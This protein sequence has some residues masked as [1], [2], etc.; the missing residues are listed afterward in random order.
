MGNE[1]EI[2][3]IDDNV[4][5]YEL[6]QRVLEKASLV[7]NSNVCFQLIHTKNG[8]E[9]LRRLAH[10]KPDCV[11]LDYSLPGNDGLIVL[12]EIKKHHP[13]LPVIMLTGQGNENLAVSLLKAGAQDYVVK[14]NIQNNKLH[15]LIEDAIKNCSQEELQSEDTQSPLILIVDDNP[16]DREY[17][18]RI[19][20]KLAFTHYHF[21]EASSGADAIK[22][23]E[24]QTPDCILLDYS[25]PGDN[26]LA[27]LKNISGDYPFLPVIILTG[28]GNEIVAAEA[29]K[30]GAQ[31]YL[32]KSGLTS[33]ALDHAIKTALEQKNLERKVSEKD[34]A[35]NIYQ[36]EM[37]DRRKRLELIVQAAN[38]VLWDLDINK[39]KIILSE[40]V[41]SMLGYGW[42]NQTI[43]LEKVA[44]LIH[45]EDKYGS[46][47]QWELHINGEVSVYEN[48]QRMQCQNGSWKWI[49]ATGKIVAR[50]QRGK[51]IQ[52]AG[53]YQDITEDKTAAEQLMHANQELERFAYMASHDLQEPL[54]MVINFTRLLEKY[55]GDQLDDRA[56]EYINFAS[57]S[58]TRMQNLVQDLL[59]YARIG[60]EAESYEEI[61]LNTL[62]DPILENLSSSIKTSGAKIVWGDLPSVKANPARMSSLFQNLIGNAIKYRKPEE[63]PEIHISVETGE[64]NWVFS[65]KD[66]GIG[67]K[68]Q[69]CMKIFEPFKRLHAKGKYAGTGMG[70]AICRKIVEG[71]GGQIW[72]TSVLGEGST[73]C[74]IVPMD[75]N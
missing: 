68:Q 21:I 9:G 27:V 61:D 59:E 33:G 51:P 23:L 34:R 47:R 37:I 64:N 3:I 16:D 67:M 57:T 75:V 18:I 13:Y 62:R 31:H 53:I 11:L 42:N 56:K 52:I 22:Q 26:G 20:K 7:N 43:E 60:E 73:F 41:E 12:G 70:L 54:R 38:L 49:R 14:S 63:K 5:D 29:I 45:P 4:D 15:Q 17:I 50:D 55:Y 72:A 19:L 28:Q 69:Y 74:F 10:R 1:Y 2:L 36:Q 66:N 71:L 8:A 35:I 30:T 40:Q 6:C 25:L 58:A 24:A 39:S 44:S 46:N 65:V 32:V 48:V